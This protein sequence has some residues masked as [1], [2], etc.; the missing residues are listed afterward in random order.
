MLFCTDWAV[1]PPIGSPNE[2]VTNTGSSVITGNV[3]VSPGTSV[4]GFFPPGVI[5]G[6][7]IQA[8]NAVA[9]QAQTDLTTAY[10]AVAGTACTL[11]LTGQNLGGLTLTPGVYCFS[12]SAALTG[13]LTLNFL[14]NP[15]AVFLFKIGST[16]TTASASSVLL[17][18][19]G[20]NTCPPNLFWQVGSSATLGTGS[21]LVG[22]ILALS[23]ITVTT[24]AQ[25]SGRALARN[26]A[27][28]LDT[29]TVTPCLM[30][31]P[32]VVPDD[33]PALSPMLLLLLSITLATVAVLTLRR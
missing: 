23:S 7:A 27:V 5:V 14:G 18:N 1:A 21:T 33:I 30:G 2:T 11:D 12:S 9:G 24:G 8:N 26:G 29:N 4:T 6:G 19:N 31:A 28:T 32:A 20:G 25:L 13:T 17:I 10:N 22:N 16:L 3:G 15:N